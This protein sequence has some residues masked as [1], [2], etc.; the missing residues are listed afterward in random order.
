MT[1]KHDHGGRVIERLNAPERNSSLYPTLTL[2]LRDMRTANGRDPT[3][4]DGH[5]NESWIGLALGMIV[6]DTLSGDQEGVGSRWDTLL[7]S[8][9]VNPTDAA[10]IYKLRCSVLH[11][12]G[13]PRPDSI[14]GRQVRLTSD[15]D[16]FAVDTETDG[17]AW[18]SVPVFCGVLVERIVAEAPDDWDVGSIATNLPPR[19]K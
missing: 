1:T 16:A 10:L 13:L 7:T 12:Y 2:A 19:S 15:H 5:G 4:G 6:L 3:T 17:E 11:G 9:G 14:D 18:I 8:H